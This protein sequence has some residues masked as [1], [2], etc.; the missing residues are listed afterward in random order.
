MLLDS[1]LPFPN[2]IAGCNT[3]QVFI[4]LRSEIGAWEEVRVWEVVFGIAVTWGLRRQALRD[5]RSAAGGASGGNLW[6][7][8]AFAARLYAIATP[9]LGAGR[10][11]GA[12]FGGLGLAPP[13]FMRSPLR[14]CVLAGGVWLEWGGA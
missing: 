5:R 11:S 12:I 13:G 8:G 10:A 1:N 4:G 7:P 14:G 2:C 3:W 6:R 9:R